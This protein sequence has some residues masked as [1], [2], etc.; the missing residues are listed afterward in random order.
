MSFFLIIII[1][2]PFFITSCPNSFLIKAINKLK[3][4]EA[5][6]KTNN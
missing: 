2:L 3:R 1:G 5:V 4:Y 6:I